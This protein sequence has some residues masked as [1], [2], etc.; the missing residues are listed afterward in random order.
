[1]SLE[2]G[3]TTQLTATPIDAS[4]AVVSGRTITWSSA[5]TAVATVSAAGVVTG[6][7]SG[8]PVAVTATAD[9]KVG[10]TQVTVLQRP[11]ASVTVSP[12][13]ASIEAGATVQLTATPKDAAGTALTGRTMQWASASATVAAVSASGLVTGVSVGGPVT[14]TAT[15]EGQSATAQMTITRASV[16]AVAVTP[17]ISTVAQGGSVQLAAA[18]RDA[19]GAALTDRVVA[20]SSSNSALAAVSAQGL[21]TAVAVGGPVTITAS[22][23]G[24]TGTA[25]VTVIL[26][27]VATVSVAPSSASVTV[28]GTVTLSATLRDANSNVVTGR[29]VAWSSSTPSIATV[30]SAGVVTGVAIGGPVTITATSEGRTGTAQVSVNAQATGIIVF[31]AGS[32]TAREI[33]RVDSDGNNLTQLTN[34]NVADLHPALS[35]DGTKI[36]LAHGGGLYVMNANGS[37]LTFLRGEGLAAG[38]LRIAWSPDGAQLAYVDPSYQNFLDLRSD[39]TIVSATGVFIRRLT[40]NSTLNFP[41]DRY[42][43][44]PSWSPDGTT[45]IFSEATDNIAYLFGHV[46]TY[47]VPAAGGARELLI[48]FGEPPA[49]SA[50]SVARN[51]EYSPDGARIAFE[52]NVGIAV[53][54]YV[55][56]AGGGSRQQ[57]G[58]IGATQPT[59]SPDGSQIAYLLSDD[60]WIM[61]ADG[62]NQRRVTNTPSL[63][64]LTPHWGRKAGQ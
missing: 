46:S 52:G 32:G 47:R 2:I 22:S 29:P 19:R 21:V 42:R 28:S 9:G 49:A 4:G 55:A 60:I 58:P 64:K 43:D 35:P 38:V 7:A 31:Q 36:A 15:V 11:I 8:G 45:I 25:Q 59:W 37:G 56:S 12:P 10:T 39:V 24:Q 20:W 26:P 33:W 1:V 41:S 30:S 23:E 16:A 3:T 17:G 34:D 44:N 13:S 50:D 53:G 48:P 14:I 57:V 40:S 54:I 62:T 27:P 63:G 61:N 51:A 6:V 5:N 18:V